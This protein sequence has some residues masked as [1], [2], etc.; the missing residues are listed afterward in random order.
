VQA[1][2]IENSR[3]GTLTARVFTIAKYHELLRQLGLDTIEGVKKF[4][5]QM[6]KDRGGRRDI[7]KIIL[8]SVSDAAAVLFLK[9]N[10][11]PHKKDGL[12]SLLTRGEVW[13]MSRVEWE[14]SLALQRGGIGVAEPVACGEECSP[15]WEKF[16]FILTESAHGEMTLHDF[17]QTSRSRHE[18]RRV[19]DALAVWVRKFH[20]ADFASPDL[21]TRHIFLEFGK[22]PKFCLI[23]MARLDREQIISPKLRARDLAALNISAPLRFVSA[24]ERLRFL[25][26]YGGD[27]PLRRAILK[28]TEYLLSRKKFRDFSKPNS[29]TDETLSQ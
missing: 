10:W 26:I 24:R 18:R 2:G 6:V 12:R 1:N 22:A 4:Q 15:L 14:N 17:I 16:S 19:L 29:E 8:P 21:F 5:G 3:A 23:D 11:Q 25:K 20:D 27:R 9:R 7:Q 28:R 13:S